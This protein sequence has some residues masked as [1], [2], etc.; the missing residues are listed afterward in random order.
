ME[1]YNS[2]IKNIQ[3]KGLW[4]KYDI[5]WKLHPD[6]NILAGIN[7]SGKS[8]VLNLITQILQGGNF[9]KDI[10]N[11]EDIISEVNIHFYGKK[12]IN[13]R[14]NQD[15]KKIPEIIPVSVIN[16]FDQVIIPDFLAQ[17]QYLPKFVKTN[18]DYNIF[19]LQRYYL[20]YQ[21]NLG[22]RIEQ[23]FVA[24]DNIDLKTKRKE[25]YGNKDLFLT[26]INQ[27]FEKTGKKIESDKNNEIVFHKDGEI[28]TPYQLS[29]GEKQVLIILLSV[30]IQ[31]NQPYILIMDEPEISLHIDW[32]EN[33]IKVIRELNNNVQIILTTHSPALVMRAWMDKVTEMEDITT[34]TRNPDESFT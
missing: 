31:D 12:T 1:L 27:L 34:L 6:V 10:E 29:S 4:K 13:I 23:A 3:I 32:Q 25:I 8:T 21:I 22:K 26:T 2:Y 18:L 20:S 24:D 33:L 7:G 28:L 9:V 15:L 30:L 17:N 11:I 5:N 19:N 14:S 16:T